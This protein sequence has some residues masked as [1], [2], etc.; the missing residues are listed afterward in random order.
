M[1]M[2]VVGQGDTRSLGVSKWLFRLPSFLALM[3]KY[4]W[5]QR[6]DFR[7]LIRVLNVGVGFCFRSSLLISILR[8]RVVDC[9]FM[10]VPSRCI[11]V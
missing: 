3:F 8:S 9:G 5:V 1:T 4:R 11:A 2:T 7:V 6:S 10:S